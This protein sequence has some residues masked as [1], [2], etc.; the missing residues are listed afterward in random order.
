[1]TKTKTLFAA[2]AALATTAAIAMFMTTAPA[3]SYGESA[4]GQQL[5]AAAAPAAKKK[6]FPRFRRFS[7]SWS[8]KRDITQNGDEP[9]LKDSDPWDFKKLK[10]KINRNVVKLSAEYFGPWVM[11]G[12]YFEEKALNPLDPGDPNYQ[13]PEALALRDF[14]LSIIPHYKGKKPKWG[15]K[16][17]GGPL[18]MATASKTN[19]DFQVQK[20]GTF[21]EA[22]WYDRKG[23][24]LRKLHLGKMKASFAKKMH[25][26]A[27]KFPLKRLLPAVSNPK[28]MKGLSVGV[29][30]N[31]RTAAGDYLPGGSWARF[32]GTEGFTIEVYGKKNR[33]F[34]KLKKPR[35]KGK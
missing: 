9:C 19:S 27:I 17:R 23:S 32:G 13:S 28:K 5:Q 12:H 4:G 8:D 35:K 14:G 22:R 20:Y 31:C 34:L 11:D 33:A 24:F 21:L 3:P 18:V 16:N 29:S 15:D 26:Y 30:T 2:L 25:V 1:V 6:K 7:K 10:I